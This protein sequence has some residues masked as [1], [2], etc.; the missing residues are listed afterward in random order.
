MQDG[1]FQT[2]T[3]NAA[4][5]MTSETNFADVSTQQTAYKYNRLG[6][7]RRVDVTNGET[8]GF[9]EHV[10]FDSRGNAKQIMARYASDLPITY[11]YY[12]YDGKNRMLSE[13]EGV[14]TYSPRRVYTFDS[15]NNVTSVTRN[16]GVTTYSYD[17]AN[18]LISGFYDVTGNMLADTNDDLENGAF[19][20]YDLWNRLENYDSR[21]ILANYTYDGDG[22]RT[23]KTVGTKR[24]EYV[25]SGDELACEIHY[26]NGEFQE[27]VGHYYTTAG[28]ALSKSNL[29]TVTYTADTHGNVVICETTTN[30]GT[31]TRCEYSY[32]AYGN[33]TGTPNDGDTNPF[34]YCGEY[35]DAE[36]GFIYLR[37]R[38]YD[39]ATGRFITEDPARDGVNWYV[40]C[41]GNPVNRIDP[42]GLE[43]VVV[44]GSEH[45]TPW[46]QRYM[47]NF[48]EPAIKKL[49]ELKKLNDGENITWLISSTGYS[50]TDISNFKRS[51]SDIGVAISFFNNKEQLIDYINTKGY[52][53]GTAMRDND[54]IHKFVVFSHGLVGSIEFGYHQRNQASLSFTQSDINRLRTNA[55]ENPN[56]C[57]YSCNTATIGSGSGSFAQSW[58]N[59]TKGK[60]WAIYEKSD[61]GHLNNPANW[62]TVVKPEREMRGYR[63]I[64]SDY[65]PIPSAKRN[66][67]W[68]TFT[69]KQNYFWG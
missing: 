29:R 11:R 3:Y 44:S 35:Y 60:T 47:Y 18:R 30:D 8:A 21:G 33:Q 17:L 68:K 63:N 55:F 32:N 24:T 54:R 16:E 62:S 12:T 57:F 43:Y 14:Q 22:R 37:N 31:I 5:D 1:G 25:W 27:A 67:Y 49:R 42:W 34:R 26:E 28:I 52:N 38:Y 19:M 48:I 51:A 15:K 56:S 66:A 41:E 9:K 13:A 69:A 6:R 40:Y 23:S 45:N 64:G 10:M 20:T 53:G 59:K 4:G 7:L 46:D 2:Y 50:Q 58:V 36:S 39:P 65:Y 61:Y